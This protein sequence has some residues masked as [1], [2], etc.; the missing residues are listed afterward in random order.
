M[1]AGFHTISMIALL[2]VFADSG[3]TDEQRCSSDANPPASD[4]T[5]VPGE[6]LIAAKGEEILCVQE[7]GLANLEQP[8][9]LTRH[10]AL[11]IASLTKQF[12]AVGILKLVETGQLSLDKS[13]TEILPD[14][15]Q[16]WRNITVRQLLSH[17]SG[18][19]GN[20]TPVFS[21]IADD[22]APNELVALFFDIPLAAQPGQVWQYSN[23]NYWIL[24]LVIETISKRSY[25]DYIDD[26][27]LNPAGLSKTRYG[28]NL[29]IISSRARGYEIDASGEITNARYFSSSI[30]YAAGG[31]VSSALDMVRWYAALGKGRIIS[32]A[33]LELALTPVKTN[34][35]V[36]T[37]FG[38]GWY[39]DEINNQRVAYHGGSSIGF[40]SYVIW[41]PDQ[42]IF[43]GVFRTWSDASGEPA[44]VARIMFNRALSK[45]NRGEQ[46][47]RKSTD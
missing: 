16:Q 31:Y 21:H 35:G 46:S 38:L 30:G 26:E 9:A 34:D 20:M 24:G 39:L 13:L 25:Q 14:I 15:P 4:A 7:T 33:I 37:G 27:V 22:L 45:Q 11:R 6:I 28:D 44:S 1:R 42:S 10:H 41:A 32:S 40:M 2:L 19:T 23:L 3:M 36:S 17:T 12:T 5:H 43:S 47:C 29:A 8:T 18:L